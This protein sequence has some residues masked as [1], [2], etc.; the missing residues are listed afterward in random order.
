MKAQRAQAA[1]RSC[2]DA[3]PR[4]VLGGSNRAKAR[5]TVSRL[6]STI[7]DNSSNETVSFNISATSGADGLSAAVAAI[8]VVSTRQRLQ[9]DAV[10][11]YWLPLLREA[12]RE[13][14][15]LL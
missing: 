7:S 3:A 9:P 6:A 12:V 15:P 10:E 11:Q 1:M 2:G 5:H 13:L 14:R 4:R 8:N